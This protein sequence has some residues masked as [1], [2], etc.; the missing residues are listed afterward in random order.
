MRSNLCSKLPLQIQ[1]SNDLLSTAVETN[2]E[3][4]L[5]VQSS[6]SDHSRWILL[7]TLTN[8]QRL[9]AELFLPHVSYK[10]SS[11]MNRL[12]EGSS[13]ERHRND[14]L[15]KHR[16]KEERA[17]EQRALQAERERL[18]NQLSELWDAR[19]S[20]RQ[21]VA[22][23]INDSLILEALTSVTRVRLI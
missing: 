14:L 2:S 15:A 22:S 10:L 7:I 17:A 9:L 20:V 3:L 16:L 11:N 23:R 1:S 13:L 4:N 6:L 5:I 12:A 18:L 19:F 21:E 8:G